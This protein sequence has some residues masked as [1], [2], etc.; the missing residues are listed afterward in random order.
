VAATL[1]TKWRAKATLRR[2]QLGHET[3][4][5]QLARID[6]HHGLLTA[7]LLRHHDNERA[8]EAV[9]VFSRIQRPRLS[10]WIGG[11]TG[12]KTRSGTKSRTSSNVL[13]RTSTASSTQLPEASSLTP[14]A[15]QIQGL[16]VSLCGRCQDSNQ[17]PSV[18]ELV[19]NLCSSERTVQ[20]VQNCRLPNT[21][22]SVQCS[23]KV[24]KC[25]CRWPIY[26]C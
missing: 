6:C 4:P 17:R 10:S 8:K 12:R 19:I 26:L 1:T 14:A 16:S 5:R 11:A 23:A 9:K 22:P 25:L 21:R 13:A 2:P 20:T 24:T 3:P 18:L 15:S 7:P